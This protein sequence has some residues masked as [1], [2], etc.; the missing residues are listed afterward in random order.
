MIGH[1]LGRRTTLEVARGRGEEADL[2]DA[3]RDLLAERQRSRLAGVA[4]LCLDEVVGVRLDRIGEAEQQQGPLGRRRAAPR[5]E[6]VGSG[7]HGGV[8]IDLVGRRAVTVDETRRWI[9]DVERLVGV[10]VDELAVDEV[11]EHR[12]HGILLG[13][14]GGCPVRGRF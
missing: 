9:D 6:R 1:V 14:D 2:V 4:D 10:G 8:D 7:A 11:A 5:L 13:V 12:R 3:R